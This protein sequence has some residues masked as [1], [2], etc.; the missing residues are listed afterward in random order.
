MTAVVDP[1]A[2]L[3]SAIES[4]HWSESDEG[5]GHAAQC[6]CKDVKYDSFPRTLRVSLESI[7]A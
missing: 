3:P 7:D 2:L 1:T 5:I 4:L 6:V